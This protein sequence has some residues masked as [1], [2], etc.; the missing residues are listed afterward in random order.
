MEAV[1]AASLSPRLG[2]RPGASVLAA[3]LQVRKSCVRLQAYMIWH[4]TL[5]WQVR[6]RSTRRVHARV[7]A[8][9]HKFG[10]RVCVQRSLE[11]TLDAQRHKK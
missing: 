3:T 8:G 10:D 5:Q 9:V 4:T 11:G 7:A 1:P 2:G 6:S